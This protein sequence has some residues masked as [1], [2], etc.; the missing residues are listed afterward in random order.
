M[1]AIIF[2]N[3]T[4]TSGKEILEI[5]RPG[6]RLI[7]ADGGA[8]NCRALGLLPEVVVGDLDS[9]SEEER[10]RLLELG[11]RILAHPRNKDQTDLELALRYAVE[12]GAGEILLLG[13]LGGRLDQTLANLLLLALPDWSSARLAVVDGPDTAYLL[14]DGESV[15]LRGRPGELVSLLPLSPLVLGITVENLRWPLLSAELQ[16]GSTHGISNEL[17]AASARVRIGAGKLLV[18]HRSEDR[19]VSAGA[20]QA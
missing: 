1:R 14:R 10:E 4:L 15:E 18:V 20:P 13:L 16:F 2:A 3:G 6:D 11:T 5:I 17:V 19:P 8:R 12:N 9:I 7:A